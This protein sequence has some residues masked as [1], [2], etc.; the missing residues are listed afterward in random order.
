LPAPSAHTRDHHTP[1]LIVSSAQQAVDVDDKIAHLRVVN[2]ALR[3]AAP[4][5]IAHLQRRWTPS[6]IRLVCWMKNTPYGGV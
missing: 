5:Q 3:F 4:S 6:I 2:S 1:D